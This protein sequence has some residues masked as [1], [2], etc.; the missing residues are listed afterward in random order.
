MNRRGCGRKLLWRNLRS[1]DVFSEVLGRC[2]LQASRRGDGFTFGVWQCLRNETVASLDRM[3]LTDVIRVVDGVDLVRLSPASGFARAVSGEEEWRWQVVDR[4]AEL[5]RSHVIRLRLDDVEGRVRH[6]YRHLF[7]LMMFA[8][9]KM[10]VIL[11]PLGFQFMAV[12]SG[13]AL[14]LSKMALALASAQAMKKVTSAWFD[15]YHPPHPAYYPHVHRSY[16]PLQDFQS[17]GPA[18]PD[19]GQL[20]HYQ[21]QQYQF[22]YP[23]VPSVFDPPSDGVQRRSRKL[24]SS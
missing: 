15:V 3:I 18:L 9:M 4:V 7:P 11:V 13:K 20:P 22:V 16:H 6:H 19:A 5:F 24:L 1:W 21:Q 8:F 14:L 12:I 10:L 23:S 17:A 2:R